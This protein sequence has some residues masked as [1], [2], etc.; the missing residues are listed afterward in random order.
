MFQAM[1]TL[2][3]L[4]I[5]IV[6]DERLARERL[7]ALLAELGIGKIIGEANSGIQA[8]EFARISHP[9]IILLDIQMPHMDGLKAATHFMEMSPSPVLIFTTAH[10]DHALEA[11]EHQAVDYLMKPIRKERLEKALKRAYLIVNQSENSLQFSQAEIGAR[12][13]ITIDIQNETHFIPVKQI[14][15]FK[16]EGRYLA[17]HWMQ[18]TVLISEKLKDLEKEFAG[19]F[20]RIHRSTLVNVIHIAYLNKKIIEENGKDRRFYYL[21]LKGIDESVEVSRRYLSIIK[22][23]LQDLRLPCQF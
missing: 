15:Y 20:L 23:L 11:F 1:K 19:Q 10:D 3:T 17:V 8:I 21:K 9:D 5:M 12:S 13:H 14:Y 7:Q 6:D 18:G 16:G 4:K 22:P 2:A